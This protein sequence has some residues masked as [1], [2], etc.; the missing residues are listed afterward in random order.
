MKP[1]LM[2]THPVITKVKVK[3][4]GDVFK[5]KEKDQKKNGRQVGLEGFIFYQH[6]LSLLVNLVHGK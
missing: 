2:D 5:K 6:V 4:Q 1:H 3:Y